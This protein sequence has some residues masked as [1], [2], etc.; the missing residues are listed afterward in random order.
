MRAGLMIVM[1]AASAL[2]T[3][4]YTH[5]PLNPNFEPYNANPIS[6][7]LPLSLS[8]FTLHPKPLTLFLSLLSSPS[9]SLSLPLSTLH[10]EPR[11]LKP[12]P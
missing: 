9:L 8:L 10:P 1:L 5:K 7:A 6:P 2:T 3:R 4:A 12:K 11:T